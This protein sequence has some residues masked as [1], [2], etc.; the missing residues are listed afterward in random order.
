VF[1]DDNALKEYVAVPE[2]D[3]K[4]GEGLSGTVGHEGHTGKIRN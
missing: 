4:C 2:S 1:S 3:L